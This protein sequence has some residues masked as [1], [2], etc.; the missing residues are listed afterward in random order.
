MTGL[1]DAILIGGALSLL[2]G[3]VAL[4]FA[5]WQTR[6]GRGGS[7][8]WRAARWAALAPLLLAPVIFAIPETGVAPMH[9]PLPDALLPATLGGPAAGTAGFDPF[10]VFMAI[11]WLP[12]LVALY[13]L[14]LLVALAGAGL[15]HFR[16]SALLKGSRPA[17]DVAQDYL[18]ILASRVGVETPDF[19]L[20]DGL[21]SPLLTGWSPVILAAPDLLDD[22]TASRYALTHELVHYRRGDEQDRLLGAA[23]VAVLWFH[24]P[25]RRIERELHE[26]REIDCDA[27]SL[28]ALGGAERKPYAATLI[29]MMRSPAHPVSAFGPDDRRHREMRIKAI[30]SGRSARSSSRLLAVLLTGVSILPVACAQA[31]L[32]ERNQLAVDLSAPADNHV[33]RFHS[34]P[35]TDGEV[36]EDYEL[37]F[38]EDIHVE[39]DFEMEYSHDGE[40]GHR[41]FR[42]DEGHELRFDPRELDSDETMMFI[43][44]GD[45]GETVI[46]TSREGAAGG[47]AFIDEDG[48]VTRFDPAPGSVWQSDDGTMRPLAPP[49]A[50]TGAEPSA[51]PA[52]AAPA[53]EPAP[54]LD[55]V[56]PAAA[57]RPDGPKRDVQAAEAVVPVFTHPVA[58]GRISS[59][60]G[61]R[62][63][64]PAGIPRNHRGT[65]IAAPTGTPI[66][67][68]GAGTVTHAAAGLNG[69]DAWGNTVV[70]DHGAG[71]QTV[72]AHMDGFDVE[73]GD[74]VDAGEQIGR[75]GSTGRSTGPHVHVEL[76]QDGERID[77]ATRLPGLR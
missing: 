75:V 51:E 21:P 3:L 77:P 8:L 70:I 12:V 9:A 19:R 33:V 68:P 16:R 69:S 6:R 44:D 64:A 22:T 47:Y 31:A 10:S 55:R 62:P 50:P 46:F 23:L 38:D 49:A 54:V 74:F 71:W 30:L 37:H 15:R 48:H 52:P 7:G 35:Q 58:D 57:P 5:S 4:C 59:R 34:A 20:R 45:E 76:R 41:V 25:L 28:E 36:H 32:T 56:E 60:Y 1:L 27:E 53:T 14:G 26:A 65:D 2:S 67:A 13:G 72:Y 63:S 66:R 61:T 73:V 42:T 40:D 24:W 18:S 17:P 11:E 39:H 43:P 29:T